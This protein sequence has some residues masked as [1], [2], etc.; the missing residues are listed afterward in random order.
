VWGYNGSGTRLEMSGYGSITVVRLKGDLTKIL[1]P[2]NFS[3][4][5]KLFFLQNSLFCNEAAG[6]TQP[7]VQ[8]VLDNWF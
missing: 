5:F 3:K 1:E 4:L 2:Y 6:S 7:S 8:W